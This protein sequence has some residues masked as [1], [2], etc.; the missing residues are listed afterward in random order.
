MN[1]ILLACLLAYS[2]LL[3]AG[4]LTQDS[5]LVQ[6]CGA[7]HGIDGNSPLP[8]APNLAGQLSGYLLYELNAYKTHERVDDFMG[9]IIDPLTEQQIYDLVKYYKAQKFIPMPPDEPPDPKLVEEGKTLYA[10]EISEVGLSCADCH[11]DDALGVV[12][13]GLLKDFPRLAGQKYDYLVSNLQQY[14]NRMKHHS[15]LGMR[16]V[17]ATLNDQEIKALASYLSS[18][19]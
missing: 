18:M 15:L 19:Q 11:G 8:I 14:A 13:P 2:P 6:T 10:K 5:E 17:A 1:R 9:D 7:C 12:N 4:T 16:A 3:F